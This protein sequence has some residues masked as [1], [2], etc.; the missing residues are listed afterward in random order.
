MYRYPDYDDK[1]LLTNVI[2]Q[3]WEDCG[4][5]DQ[6]IRES[7]QKIPEYHRNDL[8]DIGCGQG[9]LLPYFKDCFQSIVAIEPDPCRL[10]DAKKALMLASNIQFIHAFIQQFIFP[11]RFDFIVCSHLIQHM[12]TDEIESILSTVLSFMKPH[13][14]LMLSTTNWLDDVDQ[15]EIRNTLNNEFKIVS[16]AEFNECARVSDRRL[17]TRHF[18]E[19]TLIQL[20]TDAQF[21]ILFLKKY[22]GFP[23]IRGDNFILAKAK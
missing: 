4:L 16:E 21:D 15:F 12:P 14:H 8:L 9:R 18:S 7:I 22:H 19:K 11:R 23:K 17:P 20:L 2:N 3:D 1:N 5:E 6:Y 10:E 13:A